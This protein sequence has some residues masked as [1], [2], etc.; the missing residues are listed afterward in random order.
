MG[1]VE[2]KIK[3]L[4]DFLK[5]GE[6]QTDGLAFK[7]FSKL[8]V[9]VCFIG[10]L[11]CVA[12]QYFGNPIVCS[13]SD[14]PKLSSSLINSHCWI[15]GASWIGV[16]GGEDYS[17]Q[18][19]STFGCITDQQLVTEDSDTHY[20]Q[21][22]VFIL[23]IHGVIFL[24]PS[25]LWNFLEGGLMADFGSDAKSAF[26]TADEASLEQRLNTYTKHF[27][28]L[29]TAYKNSY[30]ASYLLCWVLN[31]VAAV[32]NFALANHFLD[33]KFQTYGSDI[34]GY[35]GRSANDRLNQPNPM[36][37]AFPTKVSCHVSSIA[38]SGS[39]DNDKMLCIL[40]QNIINQ[41]IYLALW[42][43]LM[44]L[45]VVSALVPIYW[46]AVFTS[47]SMRSGV[48]EGKTR[49]GYSVKQKYHSLAARRV[50]CE[51]TIGEWFILTQVGN[52]CNSYF[53]RALINKMEEAEGGTEE[54]DLH[55]QL[56]PSNQDN[57]V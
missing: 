49:K 40:N 11:L 48:L 47:Q 34:I 13:G 41:K 53:F 36:C 3:A 55:L 12:T 38:P 51:S 10:A 1:I 25:L 21:W 22:V 4:L 50:A 24:L 43:V 18:Y 31:V 57:S 56:L 20:Y 5:L 42:F 2:D 9:G 14:N 39:V 30:L 33:G 15:H 16:V 8:A 45:F 37:N 46:V 32:L 27:K 7:L 44:A 19:Q 26:V 29:G 23:F 17:N 35:Y 54:K 28:S 52:N 6:T